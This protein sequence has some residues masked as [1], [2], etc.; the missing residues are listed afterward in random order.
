M[1]TN[2]ISAIRQELKLQINEKTK[3]SYQSFFKELVTAY[4]I[5][6]ATVNKIARDRFKDVKPLGKQATFALCEKLLESDYNEEAFIALQWAYWLHDEYEPGDFAILESWIEKYIN[7]WAKCDT[8]CN[9]AVGSFIE[10]FPQ[11][12]DNLKKWTAS[13]NRWLRRAS[14]VTLIIPAKRGKFLSDIFHIADSLLQDKD[15]L[16]QKGYGWMLKEASIEHQEEVFDYII[17][18]KSLMPRTAL[19]YAI[20]RMPKDLK[21]KAM[22]KP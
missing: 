15:D 1:N 8:L 9:H 4:G 17:R 18:N 14:A 13:E 10:R 11:Y 7:N 12:I 19:R 22:A 6:T 2:I 3:Q 16:V 20:E 5:K 21:Q